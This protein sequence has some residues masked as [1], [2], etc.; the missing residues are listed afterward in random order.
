[1]GR[2]LDTTAKNARA[3]TTVQSAAQVF[4]NVELPKRSHFILFLPS[5]FN[6]VE[7]QCSMISMASVV[8]GDA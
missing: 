8:S 2:V 6:A 1:M 7:F 4:R 5:K 3:A